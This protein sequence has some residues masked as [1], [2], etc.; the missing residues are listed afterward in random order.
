M[1]LN[2]QT[3]GPTA[4]KGWKAAVVDAVYLDAS[5]HIYETELSKKKINK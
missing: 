5:E 3:K 4:W 1:S 2:R